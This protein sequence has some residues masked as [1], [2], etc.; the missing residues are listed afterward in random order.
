MTVQSIFNDIFIQGWFTISN[1]QIK[2]IL[3]LILA[4]L[5]LKISHKE[6]SSVARSFFKGILK[7]IT[8]APE[9]HSQ[10]A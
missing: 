5:K 2:K 7:T 10:N 4:V 1:Y 3:E 8:L 6:L 9:V